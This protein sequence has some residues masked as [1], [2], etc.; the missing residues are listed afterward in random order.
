M[1]PFFL[2]LEGIDSAGK[3]T[4]AVMLKGALE[5][6]GFDVS[7]YSYR[8]YKSR[9]GEIIDDFL[10]KKFELEVEEQFM[11]YLL[12]MVK[13]GRKIWEEMG[14]K[15]I[16]ADRYFVSAVAYQSAGGL[17]Y[18]KAKEICD[19]IGLPRP[20]LVLYVDINV[21]LSVQRKIRNGGSPDR[22]EAAKDYL[23]RVRGVYEMLY[24]EGYGAESWERID[25]AQDK[26][27]VHRFVFSAAMK[28]IG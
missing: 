19:R 25:G 17:E 15:I 7:L 23:N 2:C 9:Y 5:R 21:D 16:I 3:N 24:N 13:D 27:E 22:F 18:L 14:K 8:D 6:K 28:H 11:L 4:Q 1:R 20:N 12:D 26:E 10:H